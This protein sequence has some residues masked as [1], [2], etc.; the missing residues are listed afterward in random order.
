MRKLAA[1][2][3]LVTAALV[4]AASASAGRDCRGHHALGASE[5]S[6]LKHG[7]FID[8]LEDAR[9]PVWVAV[10]EA[11]VALRAERVTA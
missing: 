4:V 10:R 8:Q 11:L 1:I 7:A 2:A 3:V 9:S 5:L 6:D